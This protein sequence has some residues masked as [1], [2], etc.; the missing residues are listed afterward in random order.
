[1]PSNAY[2][3]Y[4][5]LLLELLK[6]TCKQVLPCPVC[7]LASMRLQRSARPD[8]GLEN[9]RSEIFNF[10]LPKIFFKA[11]P[12]DIEPLRYNNFH[13]LCVFLAFVIGTCSKKSIFPKNVH[14]ISLHYHSGRVHL[15]WL[16]YS[17]VT[18][19]PT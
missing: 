11:N 16:Q 8:L 17:K 7:P 3:T 1:M 2:G 18:C 14:T 10:F 5:K 4:L 13:F 9:K 15:I 12:L 19:P 6:Y